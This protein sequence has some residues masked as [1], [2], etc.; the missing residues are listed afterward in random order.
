VPSEQ[1]GYGPTARHICI[2]GRQVVEME[3]APPIQ[4]RKAPT[5]PTK[6]PSTAAKFTPISAKG[7]AQYLWAETLV[8]K[9][10][11]AALVGLT[12][13]WDDEGQSPAQV[14]DLAYQVARAAIKR[15]EEA[16]EP[17]K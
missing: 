11:A 15:L 7:D 2:A 1:P 13:D 9:F 17:P 8:V 12:V 10:M 16:Q 3:E 4:S 6:P 5:P 14:A